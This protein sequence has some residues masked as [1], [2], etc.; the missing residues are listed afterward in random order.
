[1]L[2]FFALAAL[3]V[4]VGCS[5]PGTRASP[6]SGGEGGE[7][8]T[9]GS[10]GTGTGGSATGGQGGRTVETI[11]DA[12]LPIPDTASP[13]PD[14]QV[15][16]QSLPDGGTPAATSA[17][18]GMNKPGGVFEITAGASRTNYRLVLPKGYDGT[19]PYP[20]IFYLHG[21]GNGIEG[22]GN[23]N[24]DIAAA[25]LGLVVYPKSF[26][27]SGWEVPNRDKPEENQALLKALLEHLQAD[28]CVNPRKVIMTG[29]SSGCWLTSRLACT[30]KDQLAGVV[31]AG[32][33]LDPMGKCTDKIPTTYIIGR[34]DPRF[35]DA[36][37]T[38]EFYRTRNACMMT[39]A[40]GKVPPCEDYQGC[41]MPTS[42]CLHPGGHQWPG[43][44]SKA[45]VDLLSKL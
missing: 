3:V 20:V 40:A 4:S 11:A 43:F 5:S 23:L 15:P 25:D 1:V 2:R 21:R 32:C 13:P 8:S 16:P 41:A 42:Y 36:A 6:G 38:T 19:K 39:R 10:S 7:P 31:G 27:G 35:G 18:C 30:M 34:G 28:Y 29:F 33:G 44:A 37:M 14:V 24:T 26:G 22:Q 45:V 9:G 17:G 12:A